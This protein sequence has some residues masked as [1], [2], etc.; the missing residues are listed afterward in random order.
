VSTIGA[1]FKAGKKVAS[2]PLIQSWRIRGGKKKSEKKKR[3]K[4]NPSTNVRHPGK[5]KRRARR[6]GE[7]TSY[8]K[9]KKVC[10]EVKREERKGKP[11]ANSARRR[12]KGQT[13]F[14][15]PGSCQKGNTQLLLHFS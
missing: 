12:G 3:F 14:L 15:P 8:R 13:R 11:K 9:K 10:R 1:S 5:D 2:S 4:N 7:Q 6:G